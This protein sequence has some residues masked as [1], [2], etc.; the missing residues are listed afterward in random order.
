MNNEIK[1]TGINVKVKGKE[2]TLTVDEA[3]ELKKEL[4]ALLEVKMYQPYV[5][6][7]VHNYPTPSYRFGETTC[8][9]LGQGITAQAQC[10]Y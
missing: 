8:G 1:I 6:Y 9:S 4:D 5:P 10:K 3:R 7:V 2:L